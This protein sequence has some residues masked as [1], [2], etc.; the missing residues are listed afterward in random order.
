M[1]TETIASPLPVAPSTPQPPLLLP[2]TITTTPASPPTEETS[3]QAPERPSQGSLGIGISQSNPSESWTAP[4]DIDGALIR[5]TYSY[6]D[7]V[8]VPG[9]GVVDGVELTRER[10][11]P[12]P[13]AWSDE[14]RSPVA[15]PSTI[16]TAS[17]TNSTTPALDPDAQRASRQQEE[18]EERRL[19]ERIKTT[20]RYGFFANSLA[21]SSHAKAVVLPNGSD[22]PDPARTAERRREQEQALRKRERI[23]IDKWARML[24]VSSR[25]DGGNATLYAIREKIGAAG[26]GA[27]KAK[28]RKL[29]RRVYKGIPD[30]W[31]SAVWLALLERRARS[32][33]ASKEGPTFAALVKRYDRLVQE[34][35]PYDVQIDLD[36]PRTMSGH[37]LFHTRYGQGQRALFHVLH[38]FSLH[39]P[40]CGYCQGMGPIAASLL[41][42]LEPARAYAALIRLHDAH[43]LHNIFAPGFPGL[44]ENFYVQEQLIKWLFPA[45]HA[46]MEEHGIDSSSF[47][48]KWYITLFA[49]SVPF[50]TQ[51]R[52]WDIIFLDGQDALVGV[53]LGVLKGIQDRLQIGDVIMFDTQPFED[54]SFSTRGPQSSHAGSFTL[55]AELDRLVLPDAAANGHTAAATT[56]NGNGINHQA[57]KSQGGDGR[58]PSLVKPEQ[59]LRKRPSA[60]SNMSIF[61]KTPKSSQLA[62]AQ[63]QQQPQ[64][65]PT[66]PTSPSG[67]PSFESVLGALTSYIIPASDGQLIHTISELMTRPEVRARMKAARSEWRKQKAAG[68]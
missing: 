48:T 5:R 23:R 20:D 24:S 62:L 60:L 34:P 12:L 29:R 59:G 3:V 19:E 18:E 52:M 36:V 11:H 6:F 31:R 33:A 43:G 15:G 41:L 30:R 4:D 26:A 42:Y 28:T 9:D 50:E 65:S 21:T 44:V 17:S 53:A 61:K 35:S 8:G 40:D 45:L 51:L 10:T 47:A 16:K 25:D 13:F 37:I 38:A 2:P 14:R 1:A 67:P 22:V 39:C 46:M 54:T 68:Q 49:N 56:A 64:P 32:V 57:E 27:S 55:S 63:Q 7:G 58:R 66:A